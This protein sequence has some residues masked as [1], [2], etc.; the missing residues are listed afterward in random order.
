MSEEQPR[1]YRSLQLNDIHGWP[2]MGDRLVACTRCASVVV[3][4]EDNLA[5]HNEYHEAIAYMAERMSNEIV[6]G[7]GMC[8][9]PSPS[10]PPEYCALR[11]GHKGWHEGSRSFTDD[12]TPIDPVR[13]SPERKIDNEESPADGRDHSSSQ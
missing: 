3:D 4:G 13:W 9:E 8:G 6:A 10:D 12:F 2:I 7:D 11:A 1:R 5:A